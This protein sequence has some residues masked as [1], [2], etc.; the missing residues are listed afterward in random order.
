MSEYDPYR[1]YNFRLVI[2]GVTQAHFTYCSGPGV[3]VE[4]IEYREAGNNQMVRRLPGRVK[5]ENIEMRFGL[6][7]SQELWDWLMASAS[8]QHQPRNVSIVYL[9]SQNASEVMRWDLINA[10]PSQWRS[11]PLDALGSE[12]AIE[13][14]VLV[15]ETIQRS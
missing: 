1:A 14:L 13:T 7:D 11:A 2:Q 15:Y 9:D 4:A 5:F 12:L 3:E 6:S 10:W 8:G